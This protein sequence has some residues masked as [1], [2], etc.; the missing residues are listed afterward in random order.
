MQYL[1]SD[2]HFGHENI[3]RYMNRPFA[4]ASEMDEA[5]VD[6]WN[7]VV[8]DKDEVYILGDV[9]FHKG[10]ETTARLIERLNGKKYLIWGNHDTKLRG[11]NYIRSL[12]ISQHDIKE[13]KGPDKEHI[14]LFHY[15]IEDWNRRY[16]GAYHFHGHTHSKPEDKSSIKNRVDVGVDAW[17]Y[18]PVSIDELLTYLQD[19]WHE[20]I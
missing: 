19:K 20:T 9:S 5:I 13:I 17:D 6:N 1:T 7:K 3:I 15:P 18:K 2:L 4:N 12:F 11:N 10:I 16:R 8:T 14:V